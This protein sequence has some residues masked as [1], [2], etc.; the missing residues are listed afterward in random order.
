MHAEY[1]VKVRLKHFLKFF[2][3]KKFS[4]ND[5]KVDKLPHFFFTYS[6][7]K[8]KEPIKFFIQNYKLSSEFLQYFNHFQQAC[9]IRLKVKH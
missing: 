9:H 1:Q 5:F 3:L 8:Y 2:L 7:S 6:I 4:L